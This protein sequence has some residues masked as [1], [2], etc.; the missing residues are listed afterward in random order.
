MKTMIKH[1]K[2]MNRKKFFLLA[3]ILCSAFSTAWADGWKLKSTTVLGNGGYW[4]DGQKTRVDCSYKNGVFQYER[5]VTEG[6]NMEVYSTKAVFSEPKQ[7][8]APGE[9]IGVRIEFS[10]NGK[11]LS[12]NPYAR[13]T[14]MPQ[15]PQWTKSSGASNKIPASGAVEGQAVDAAGRNT[16]TPPETVTLLAQA[17]TTGSQMA[18]V[19]SCNGMDVVYQYDWDGTPLAAAPEQADVFTAEPQETEIETEIEAEIET[20]TETE[21]E[22]ETEVETETETESEIASEEIEKSSFETHEAIEESRDEDEEQSM[23]EATFPLKKLILVGGLAIVLI[24]LILILFRKKDKNVA[25]PEP[26]QAPY[27]EEQPA[28]QSSQPVCPNCGTPIEAGERFCQNCGQ[29]L[30]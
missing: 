17:C 16:V 3:L 23:D 8:Y 24:V 22:I 1:S 7:N 5:K 6:K 9:D 21:T 18:I 14:V 11:K 19:Y 30:F 13:V 10:Q 27:V 29:K 15:H 26:A 2:K 4:Q 28:P 20:E 12:Y 25:A